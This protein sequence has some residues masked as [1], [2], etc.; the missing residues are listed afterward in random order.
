MRPKSPDVQVARTRAVSGSG[1]VETG[2][3]RL[4]MKMVGVSDGKLE[5]LLRLNCAFLMVPRC[6][7]FAS[8]APAVHAG[9]RTREQDRPA[10]PAPQRGNHA[11]ISRR[12][13]GFS[14]AAAPSGRGFTRAGRWRRPTWRA[15]CGT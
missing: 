2:D 12:V 3:C 8:P 7:A 6:R 10:A 11:D 4:S 13:R 15:G 14:V 1:S 9:A 5:K